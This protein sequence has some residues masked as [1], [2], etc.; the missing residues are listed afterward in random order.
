MRKKS[1][2]FALPA[3]ACVFL[4]SS[5]WQTRVTLKTFVDPSIQTSSIKSI[6]V[7]PLRNTALSPGEA[8]QLDRSITQAFSKKNISIKIIGSAEATRLLNE[9]NL[10]DSYSKFLSDF[11]HSGIPNVNTL[12]QIGNE[13]NADAILQGT[14][15][16]VTQNDGTNGFR[17]QSPLT[18][19]TLRYTLLDTN[20]G[21]TLWEGTSNA[22]KSKNGNSNKPA[23]PLYE[24]ID[25][26]LQKIL[27]DLPALGR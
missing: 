11:E 16:D 9:K 25:L 10:V 26:A 21:N 27:T 20:N 13:L 12:K 24:V 7:F 3:F 19:L 15:S 23:P 8:L 4:L 17:G 1:L 5:C 14:L 6:A 22:N 2:F 18:S